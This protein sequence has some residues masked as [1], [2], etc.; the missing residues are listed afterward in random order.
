LSEIQA[1]VPG[2]ELPCN[3]C[4]SGIAGNG[5]DA[6]VVFDADTLVDPSFLRI[7]DARLA[8]GSQVIQVNM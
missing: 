5:L 2:R 3:G 8:N 7:M 4:F 1:S 6:I